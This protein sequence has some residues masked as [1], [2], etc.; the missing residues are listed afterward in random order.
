MEL[1]P[2]TRVVDRNGLVLLLCQGLAFLTA[3]VVAGGFVFHALDLA[4]NQPAAARYGLALVRTAPGTIVASAVPAQAILAGV[5]PGS[6]VI[7]IGLAPVPEG[8]TVFDLEGRLARADATV[9][10][11][12]ETAQGRR[13]TIR[14]PRQAGVWTARGDSNLPRWFASLLSFVSLEVPPLIL[15][16]AAFLLLTKKPD[17]FEA[18]ALAIC[19]LMLCFSVENWITELGA[20]PWLATFIYRSGLCGTVAVIGAFPSGNFA[21]PGSWISAAVA[22]IGLALNIFSAGRTD[23]WAASAQLWVSILLLLGLIVAAVT[24]T[25]RFMRQTNVVER[26]QIKWVAIGAAVTTLAL[27]WVAVSGSLGIDLWLAGG[28]NFILMRLTSMVFPIGLPLGLL[29][30]VLRYR[31]Y[32]SDSIITHSASFA[33]L[34]ASLLAIFGAFQSL[35]TGMEQTLIAGQLGSLPAA[36]AA[37][38]TALLFA[39]VQERAKQFSERR[40]RPKLFHLRQEFPVLVGDLRETCTPLE[41][42]E[43]V[44][45]DIRA[46]LHVRAIAMVVEGRL[47]FVEGMESGLA[48]TWCGQFKLAAADKLQIVRTDP[49]FP[50]RLPLMADGFEMRGWLLLGPRPDGSLLGREECKALRSLAAPLARAMAISLRREHRRAFAQQEQ[51]S[52][53]DRIEKVESVV[54]RLLTSKIA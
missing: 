24:I 22:G 40:C 47:L 41:L 13:N 8:A 50:F 31:L 9:A 16:W 53:A 54:G 2:K 30:A 32:D 28:M 45:S 14:L 4:R 43:A 52:L 29:V 21:L 42:A 36:F 33:I 10:V 25:I 20:P 27:V 19:F 6:R 44:E 17:D 1:A 49:V 12:F 23:A 5:P 37:A 35:I 48:T 34:V 39:P 51:L 18:R 15:L 11:T 46:A 7:A 3:L 26:L 38:L